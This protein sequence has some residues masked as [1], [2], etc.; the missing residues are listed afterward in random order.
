MSN[1]FPNI[2]GPK[3]QR[4]VFWLV[5]LAMVSGLVVFALRG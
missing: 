1:R 2:P 3:R 4:I 5:N